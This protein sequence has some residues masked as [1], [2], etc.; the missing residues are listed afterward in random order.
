MR[1][2]EP[3]RSLLTLCS[4]LKVGSGLAP[5]HD[6]DDNDDDHLNDE[7]HILNMKVVNVTWCSFKTL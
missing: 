3:A 7:Y 6:N 1:N 4:L 5:D 2:V